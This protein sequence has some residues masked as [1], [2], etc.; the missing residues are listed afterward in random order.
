MKLIQFTTILLFLLSSFLIEAQSSPQIDNWRDATLDGGL[1][2]VSKITENEPEVALVVAGLAAIAYW[3]GYDMYAINLSFSNP[4]FSSIVVH[5]S[6][7]RIHEGNGG[8]SYTLDFFLVI[9]N[10]RIQHWESVRMPT[11][12]SIN[13]YGFYFAPQN[14]N[15]RYLK[16]R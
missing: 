16:Y 2:L 3:A 9:R 15:G 8:P 14:F 12:S 10:N 5:P 13:L 6:Q 11:G 1:A 7:F 4:N